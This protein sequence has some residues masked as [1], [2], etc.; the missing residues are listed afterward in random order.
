MVARFTAKLE[1]G[2]GYVAGRNPGIRADKYGLVEY[3]DVT[4]DYAKGLR[5]ALAACLAGT[6]LP[7]FRLCAGF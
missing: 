6:R 1:E 5:M 7:A 4:A 3:E 2:E